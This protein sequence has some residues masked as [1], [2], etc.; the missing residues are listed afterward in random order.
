MV[1]CDGL[2]NLGGCGGEDGESSS[3][4]SLIVVIIEECE[5]IRWRRINRYFLR[6]KESE[7]KIK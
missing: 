4:A 3:M 2:L 1:V 7:W 6:E 5:S